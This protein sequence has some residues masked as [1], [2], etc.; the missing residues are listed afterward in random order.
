MWI[1]LWFPADL[2]AFT[3]KVLNGKI[4]FLRSVSVNLKVSLKVDFLY[5]K[6]FQNSSR[7]LKLATDKYCF[8]WQQVFSDFWR[9]NECQSWKVIDE[10][11]GKYRGT[12]FSIKTFFLNVLQSFEN[13]E[14]FT[15][16]KTFLKKH[17]KR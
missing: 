6:P 17:L 9:S 3:K 12:I 7:G 5:F 14:K 13:V 1:N 2:S 15:L 16:R 10:Y 4:H 8:V 11:D